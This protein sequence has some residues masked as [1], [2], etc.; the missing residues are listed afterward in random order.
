VVVALGSNLGIPR[1]NV[2]RA[3]GELAALIRVVRVSRL[4][5]TEPVDAP[6][7][8]P[9]FLNAVVVGYT[10]LGPQELMDGLLAIERRMGRVRRMRNGPRVIDLDL[11]V[12]GGH[13]MASAGLVLPHPRA[14]QR[15][16]VLEPM[17]DV[18]VEGWLRG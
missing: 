18:G 7:G 10:W 5:E 8:S 14:R 16:F 4:R 2:L 9:R 13:R 15:S 17:R 3:I 6:P 11:I 1:Y 12:H